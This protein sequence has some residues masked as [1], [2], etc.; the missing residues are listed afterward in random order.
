MGST[1]NGALQQYIV[2]DLE[3]M[4]KKPSNASFASAAGF[5]VVCLTSY[6]AVFAE[7]P[8][9]KYQQRPPTGSDPS[10]HLTTV[11]IIGASGGTGSVGVQLA[12]KCGRA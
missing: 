3:K 1:S 12:K 6:D 10:K 8:A 4:T 5:G 11:L 7:S 2:A 9:S